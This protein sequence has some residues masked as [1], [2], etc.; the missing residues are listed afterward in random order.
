VLRAVSGIQAARNFIERNHSAVYLC[1]GYDVI[2]T[3][4]VD[5][6]INKQIPN[7]ISLYITS[8]VT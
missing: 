1:F 5:I 3:A 2:R 4:F 8:R 6:V 7:V